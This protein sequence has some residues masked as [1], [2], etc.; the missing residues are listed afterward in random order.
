MNGD[1][2]QDEKRGMWQQLKHI[3][4]DVLDLHIEIADAMRDDAERWAEEERLQSPTRHQEHGD[5][6]QQHG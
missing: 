6:C 4:K 1:F 2:P 3:L 5:Q